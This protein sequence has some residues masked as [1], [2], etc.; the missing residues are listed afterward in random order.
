MSGRSKRIWAILAILA[1]IALIVAWPLYKKYL[2]S[3]Q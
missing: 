1:M 3:G 2:L